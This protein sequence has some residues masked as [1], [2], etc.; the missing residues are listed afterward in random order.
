MT[1]LEVFVRARLDGIE[2]E[3]IKSE[4]FE[5]AHVRAV[6]GAPL[7]EYLRDAINREP[8]AMRYTIMVFRDLRATPEDILMMPMLLGSR[9]FI[10]FL[11]VVRPGLDPVNVDRSTSP[12]KRRGKR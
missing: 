8:F 3:E 9:S 7:P 4:G 1:P 2:F 11:S 5:K 10:Q 12:A 6:G